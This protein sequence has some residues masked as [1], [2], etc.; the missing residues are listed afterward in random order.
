MQSS[1]VTAQMISLVASCYCRIMLIT[2]GV[3]AV[4]FV[5]LFERDIYFSQ[6]LLILIIER[7]RQGYIGHI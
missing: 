3:F 6:L 1:N 4:A 5:L 2:S 7:Y